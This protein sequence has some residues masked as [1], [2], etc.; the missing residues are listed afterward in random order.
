MVQTALLAMIYT[1]LRTD[2]NLVDND[3]SKLVQSVA[4]VIVTLVSNHKLRV[5]GS[6]YSL[7][8]GNLTTARPEES[9]SSLM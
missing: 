3:C 9:R 5:A 1:L 7:S 4:R 2:D 6:T 8:G